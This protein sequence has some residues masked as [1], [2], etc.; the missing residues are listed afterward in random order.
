MPPIEKSID[1]NEIADQSML[2]HH[3]L[4]DFSD[5]VWREVYQLLPL[6]TPLTAPSSIREMRDKLWFSIDNEDSKDL[7]QITYAEQ[8]EGEEFKI[9][10]AIADVAHLVRKGCAID[11]HAQI[12][13]TSVYTPTKIFPMLPKRLST[14][15]SSLNQE[16][17]RLAVVV[18]IEVGKEGNLK[19][20]ALYPAHVRNRAKLDYNSVHEWL[21]EKKGRPQRID[22]L[23]LLE[24]NIR[25]QEK[26]A[27]K[28]RSYRHDRG[29]LT[30]QTIESHV[31]LYHQKVIDIKPEREANRARK[32]IEDFMIAANAAVA[33]F[34][35]KHR[36]PSL[37]RI[38]RA[39]KRWDR[40]VEVAGKLG[41]KLPPQPDPLA[42]EQFLIKQYLHSP[43]SFPEL[44]LIILKLLGRGE[45]VVQYAGDS[46]IGHFGLALKNYTHATA[47][48]RR[49]SDLLIQRLLKALLEGH[50]SPYT[51]VELEELARRC[52]RQED[53]AEKVERKM[54][55]SAASLLLMPH[56]GEVFDAIVTGAAPKGTWV[57][58]FHPCVEGKLVEG[59]EH[60][61]VGDKIQVKLIAV[62]VMQGFIDFSR[63]E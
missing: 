27:Q 59:F 49:Y 56:I 12:N 44:S 31:V 52:T 8:R 55:K 9:Y 51:S 42:L 3:F 1:L 37:R 30:L 25:L 16:E 62:D 43:A 10:I 34:L 17:D 15:L 47:P 18:E 39:P 4:P 38:V 35:Q 57:R 6:V 61:D 29:A 7:D 36:L 32:L 50:P 45:Y 22:Q 33:D 40:I 23:P 19:N 13:T 63:T 48:N 11:L 60:V 53:E 54:K 26:I 24:E 14:E 41:E 46:P 21:E 2:D 5:Q 20:Y 58:T 28:L